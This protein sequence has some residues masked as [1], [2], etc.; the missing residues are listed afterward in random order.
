MPD[1]VR[2]RG[3]FDRL[4]KRGDLLHHEG[5]S[6]SYREVLLEKAS[7]PSEVTGKYKSKPIDDLT[8]LE[9]FENHPWVYACV[10]LIASSIAALPII[11]WDLKDASK[12]QVTDIPQVFKTPNEYMTWYD[13]MEGLLI[14][15]EVTGEGYWE[16]VKEDDKPT[17]LYR[18]RPDLVTIVEHEKK[19][20][21]GYTYGT[22]GTESSL[23][24]E[25]VLRF[26]YFSP[27]ADFKGQGSVTALATSLATDFYSMSYN[28]NF[29]KQGGVLS[30]VATTDQK[31]SDKAFE[32]L[33]AQIQETYAGVEKMHKIGVFEEGLKVEDASTGPKDAQFIEGRKINREEILA[34][35]RVP[36]G[37]VGVLEYSSYQNMRIQEREFWDK[38]I[39]PKLRK[40]EHKLDILAHYFSPSYDVEFDL[41]GVEALQEDRELKSRIDVQE[42]RTGI[43]TVNEIRR[44]RGLEP[45]EWGDKPYSGTVGLALREQGLAIRDTIQKRE[46]KSEKMMRLAEEFENELVKIFKSMLGDKEKEIIEKLGGIGAAAIVGMSLEPYLPTKELLSNEL[47]SKA[48]PIIREAFDKF[49][50]LATEELGLGLSFDVYAKEATKVIKDYVADYFGIKR[51]LSPDIHQA[52]STELNEGFG[53]GESV[54][55]LR[56]RVQRVM[57]DYTKGEAWRARRIARTEALR[58][59][60]W[61]TL[62]GYRQSDIVK[63]KVWLAAVDACEY[64]EAINGTKKKLDE[65]FTVGPWEVQ[66]PPAHPNCRCTLT[67]ETI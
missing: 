44:E 40:I 42:I 3:F 20:I 62:E 24:V 37:L 15:L 63:Y 6:H 65:L 33:K 60:N 61:G 56:K 46:T 39:K 67:Y 38:C 48:L 54:D 21:T 7:F 14:D 59:A 5:K 43:K 11:I 64:C 9:L 47:Q 4:F 17:K 8:A 51:G 26:S 45:V 13:L 12:E 36:P 22:K 28:K 57:F 35:F 41:K 25:D 52:L 10:D 31:L 32:R 19:G 1:E 53:L 23:K 58:G 18:L 50:N 34:A 49:G 16:L 55:V 2:K 66:A 29:F 27:V 30:L